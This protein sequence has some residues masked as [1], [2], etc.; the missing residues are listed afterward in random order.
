L[1]FAFQP[2]YAAC[3]LSPL[4]PLAES[5]L[6]RADSLSALF[7]FLHFSSGFLHCFAMPFS[8]FS[9]RF[10]RFSAIY[11]RLY[12]RRYW[13]IRFSFYASLTMPAIDAIL[14]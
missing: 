8:F 5:L 14:R 1:I 7:M 9:F 11:F 3:Q 4:P 12:C 2:P 6:R 10:F 13:L